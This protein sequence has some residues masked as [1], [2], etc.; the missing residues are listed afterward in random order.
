MKPSFINIFVLELKNVTL[1]PIAMR[2][3]SLAK[4]NA[5]SAAYRTGFRRLHHLADHTDSKFLFG[6]ST[7]CSDIILSVSGF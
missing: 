1:D 4:K 3:F 6:N 7:C 5:P 2:F